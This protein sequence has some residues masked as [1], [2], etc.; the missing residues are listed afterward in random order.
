MQGGGTHSLEVSTGSEILSG[1]RPDIVHTVGRQ[2]SACVG[3][4]HISEPECCFE[5]LAEPAL[6]WLRA[7]PNPGR[8]LSPALSTGFPSMSGDAPG[9]HHE[10]WCEN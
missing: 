4:P 10:G 6:C 8:L 9:A 5:G 2:E 1:S 3:K 7:T